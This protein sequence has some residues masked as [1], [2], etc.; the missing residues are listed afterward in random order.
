MK[1]EDGVDN[2][3]VGVGTGGVGPELMD[4]APIR[5]ESRASKFPGCLQNVALQCHFDIL[6]CHIDIW[7]RHFTFS[8]GMLAPE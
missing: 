7:Q 4:L 3:E 5:A 1:C 6:Q 8:A 2:I